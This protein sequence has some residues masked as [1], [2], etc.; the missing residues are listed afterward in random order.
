MYRMVSPYS[1]Y[2]GVLR[3]CINGVWKARR[4]LNPLASGA[5][6][7]GEGRCQ[8]NSMSQWKRSQDRRHI[9]EYVKPLVGDLGKLTYWS[10]EREEDDG[11]GNGCSC[12]W[13]MREV[14]AGLSFPILV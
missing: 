12:V 3:Q 6:D 14:S 8:L 2:K 13:H 1:T 7:L 5:R 11:S 9:H 10:V 4:A